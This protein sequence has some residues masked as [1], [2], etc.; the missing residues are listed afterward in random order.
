MPDDKKTIT[1]YISV[2][3]LHR[4]SVLDV[5]VDV[6]VNAANCSLL[7]GGGVDGAIHRAAGYELQEECNSLNGCQTGHCKITKAYQIT[8]AK[9]IIHAVGPRRNERDASELL[10]NCY[11]EALQIAAQYNCHSIAFPCISTGIYGMPLEIAADQ[12]L[13]AIERWVREHPDYDMRII[14][15]CYREE[16]YK[17]YSEMMSAKSKRR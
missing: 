13:D 16:E 12:A 6:I 17:V 9:Y 8:W 5:T 7:A 11:H 4:G 10:W 2:I 1:S 15:C 14:L 3:Q